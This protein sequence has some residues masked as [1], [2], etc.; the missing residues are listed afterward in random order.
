MLGEAKSG[1][2]SNF[3][4]YLGKPPGSEGR[5]FGLAT[6][7]VLNISKPFHH[8]NRHLYFDNFFTSVDLVE[9]LLRRG[10]Y[11]CGTLRANRLPK[12]Q[13]GERR[14]EEKTGH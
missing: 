2:I 9:E 6:K 11:A 5:E 14:R 3:D 1:Y 4:I 12:C 7:V 10:T 13:Q 8:S